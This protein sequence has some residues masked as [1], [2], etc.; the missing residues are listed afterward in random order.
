MMGQYKQEFIFTLLPYRPI[1]VFKQRLRNCGTVNC[2]KSM[3]EGRAPVMDE[4]GDNFLAG[5]GFSPYQS[6]KEMFQVAASNHS[7]TGDVLLFRLVLHSWDP[8]E[9]QPGSF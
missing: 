3:I 9:N 4:S 5:S 6:R 1:F 7:E 8:A 2:N